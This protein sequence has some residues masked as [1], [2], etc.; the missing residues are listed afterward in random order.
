MLN[1]TDAA[2]SEIFINY[3][4]NNRNGND[5]NLKLSYVHKLLVSGK[6]KFHEL[7]QRMYEGTVIPDEYTD[8]GNISEY[9][10]K[11]LLD[12]LR[13]KNVHL[14]GSLQNLASN[15]K[16]TRNITM[17]YLIAAKDVLGM[18]SIT[19]VLWNMKQ[20]RADEG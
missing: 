7:E 11:E 4:S 19:E 10:P 5:V 9:T 8:L 18:G 20:L 14:D 13:K 1:C 6:M 17:N 3:I 16:R 2:A 12:L 15:A